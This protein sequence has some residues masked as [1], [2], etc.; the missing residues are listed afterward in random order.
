M[1]RL[2]R[3][4][5]LTVVLGITAVVAGGSALAFFSSAGSGNASAAV[6]T[7]TAPEIASATPAVGGTVTLS[8]GAITPPGGGPPTYYVTR[9]GGPPAGNC[10]TAGAPAAVLTCADAGLSPG[11]HSYRVTALWGTWSAASPI[12]KA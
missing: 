1:R 2:C 11:E 10:P 9:D 5:L 4:V 8:W 6:T 12:K 7:L 3:S